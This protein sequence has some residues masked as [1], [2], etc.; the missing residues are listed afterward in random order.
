MVISFMRETNGSGQYD[1]FMRRSNS[2]ES[3]AFNV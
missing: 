2:L 1:G 3:I